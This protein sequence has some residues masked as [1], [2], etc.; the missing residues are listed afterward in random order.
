[1]TGSM[2]IDAKC[3]SWYLLVSAGFKSVK[4]ADPSL[5]PSHT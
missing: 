4:V 2:I 1:M 5:L 3:D